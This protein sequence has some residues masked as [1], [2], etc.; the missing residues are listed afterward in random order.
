MKKG[1]II[2]LIVAGCLLVTGAVLVAVAGASVN[3]DFANL[4]NTEYES[5]TVEVGE[6]FKNISINVETTDILFEPSDGKEC[7]VVYYDSEKAEYSVKVSEDTLVIKTS[8]DSKWYE[9]IALFASSGPKMTV[10]LPEKEYKSLTVSSNTADADIPGSFTFET[11]QLIGDTSDFKCSARVT[12]S[13]T[14]KTSTGDI[15]IASPEAGRTEIAATTGD[16]KINGVKAKSDMSIN[17][18]TGDIKLTDTVISNS[19]SIESTTGDVRFDGSDAGTIT[20]KTTT[21]DVEGT[22]LSDKVFVT[23]TSTG[24]VKVPSSDMGGKCEI[25][26]TTGDINIKIAKSASSYSTP[27]SAKNQ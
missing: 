7:K 4:S 15:D 1:V 13:L 17:T 12:E 26:T 10:Y 5:K 2:S 24:D 11:V 3:W 27:D 8:D 19:L 14:V 20:V 21:G 23:S 6:S 25:T 22:L 9:R 16:I 18:S